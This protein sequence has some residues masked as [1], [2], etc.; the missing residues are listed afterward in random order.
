MSNTVLPRQVRAVLKNAPDALPL[1]DLLGLVDAFVTEIKSSD[2][3][4]AQLYQ[5]EEDLHSIHDDVV[6]YSSLQQSEAFLAILYHLKD[7]LPPISV[8]SWFDLVLRPALREP[9]LATEAVKQAQELIIS[10]L[11]KTNEVY[12]TK[13]EGF[14]KHLLELYLLDA[15]N[16]GSGEDVLE[17]AELNDEKRQQRTH[18]KHNLEDLLLKFGDEQPEVCQKIFYTVS[19]G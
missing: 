16:E 18:W 8:I 2:A 1:N 19:G 3:A 12:A 7:I 4:E 15:Y 11:K 13:V 10:A 17:W 9:K 14:R 5:L 6:D